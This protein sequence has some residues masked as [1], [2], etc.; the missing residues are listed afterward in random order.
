M[1][2]IKMF[3]N[4][5]KNPNCLI[6]EPSVIAYGKTSITPML[7]FQ[8]STWWDKQLGTAIPRIVDQTSRKLRIVHKQQEIYISDAALGQTPGGY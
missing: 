5:S 8:D 2:M 3:L 1:L 7:R 6:L 4:K